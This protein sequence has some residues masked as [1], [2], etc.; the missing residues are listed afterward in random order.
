MGD[1][2]TQAHR[3]KDSRHT[4]CWSYKTTYIFFKKKESRLK[5][6]SSSSCCL[7]VCVLPYQHRNVWTNLLKL[8]MHIMAP[9]TSQ[10]PASYISPLSLC[11]YMYTLSLLGNSLVKTL[12]RQW[13]YTTMDGLLEASFYIR[14]VSYERRVCGCACVS[15]YHC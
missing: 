3:R 7:T 6:K 4:A 11:L 12:P 10:R 15:R 14:S 5:N 13:I 8:A 1:T 9:E 2:D